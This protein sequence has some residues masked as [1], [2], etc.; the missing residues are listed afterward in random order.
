MFLLVFTLYV[1]ASRVSNVLDDLKNHR[2]LNEQKKIEYFLH[3]F[4]KSVNKL[5]GPTKI[6]FNFFKGICELLEQFLRK[7]MGVECVFYYTGLSKMPEKC[8]CSSSLAVIYKAQP[9]KSLMGTETPAHHVLLSL[10]GFLLQITL[11]ICSC[12]KLFVCF[13]FHIELPEYNMKNR[14]IIHKC[15]SAPV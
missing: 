5:S 3:V 11:V 9:K 1:C 6:V 7:Q 2:N 15:S 10:I 14:I 13:K 12:S 8:H 4:C